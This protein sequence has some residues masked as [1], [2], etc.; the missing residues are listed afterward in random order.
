MPRLRRE[1]KP[2]LIGGWSGLRVARASLSDGVGKDRETYVEQA[3]DRGELSRYAA[4]AQV[5]YRTGSD[6][7]WHGS[8]GLKSLQLDALSKKDA[9]KFTQALYEA[10]W[11]RLKRRGDV[12][13]QI[14]LSVEA[15]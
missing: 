13:D 2:Q 4:T 5:T 1:G 8:F 11:R 3:S 9:L 7:S 12:L 6:K 15:V 14:H 10:E